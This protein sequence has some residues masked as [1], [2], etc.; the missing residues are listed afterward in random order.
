MSFKMGKVPPGAG[1]HMVERANAVDVTSVDVAGFIF[2]TP[3]LT[4]RDDPATGKVMGVLSR[5]FDA[6]IFATDE[7]GYFKVIPA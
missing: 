6:S 7:N 1:V 5:G 4:L 2:P 3:A